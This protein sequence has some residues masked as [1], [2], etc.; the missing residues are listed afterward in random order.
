MPALFYDQRLL[1]DLALGHLKHGG[2]GRM[3]AL[4][5][6]HQLAF[7]VIPALVLLSAYIDQI[8]VHGPQIS[9]PGDAD[10]IAAVEGLGQRY[11]ASQNKGTSRNQPHRIRQGILSLFG[12]DK[13]AVPG[14][15]QKR[16][17]DFLC[18]FIHCANQIDGGHRP[19]I[20]PDK[21][22]DLSFHAVSFQNVVIYFIRLIRSQFVFSP[23]SDGLKIPKSFAQQI[24]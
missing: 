14:H 1:L 5:N 10:I 16:R 2:K 7:V 18:G 19:V 23:A 8:A 24:M 15:T 17:A 12:I 9:V 11:A 6:G 22:F 3:R 4:G 20:L 21:G 13:T